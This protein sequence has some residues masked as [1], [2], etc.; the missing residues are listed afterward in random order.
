MG[1]V[2]ELVCVACGASYAPGEV[3]YT[4]PRHDGLEGILDVRYDYAAAA[5]AGFG[6]ELLA[7]RGVTDSLR[8][9]AELLP[10]PDEQAETFPRD[11]IG[12][13]PLI[14]VPEVA[15]R[16]GLRALQVKDDGRLPTGS[17]KDRASVIGATR[18]HLEGHRRITCSSTGNAA[19]SLAGVCAHVGLEA[20]IFVPET[21]PEAKVAQLAIFGARIMLVRGSYDDAYYLCQDAVEAFGWYNRN[22]AVNPYLVEGKKTC[23]LE[24]AEQIGEDPPEWISVSVG[25][26]CTVAGIYKGLTEMARFGVIERVPKLLA[27]QAAGANPISAAWHAGRNDIDP[28]VADTVADSIAVGRP[29]NARKALTAVTNSGGAFVDVSDAEITAAARDLA[30]LG[31]VFGEPAGVAGIAGITKARSLGMLSGT[32]RVVHVVTGNGLKD[33]GAARRAAPDPP[34]IRPDLDEV[35]ALVEQEPA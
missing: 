25:D 35:R 30:S 8:R 32:E 31:G 9:Y 28:Q 27:V 23:G 26:G 19:S 20:F 12:R 21:A 3:A 10:V 4:C 1:V 22:C 2:T 33:A 29:R 13:T 14:D 5:A 18:A 15:K 7:E 24:L 6:P 17:F 11:W 16:A 34:V